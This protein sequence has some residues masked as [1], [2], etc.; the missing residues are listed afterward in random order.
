MSIEKNKR[1]NHFL[2]ESMIELLKHPQASMNG[3]RGQFK[4]SAGRRWSSTSRP[5]DSVRLTMRDCRGC[6]DNTISPCHQYCLPDR[7]SPCPVP[8]RF[9]SRFSQKEQTIEKLSSYLIVFYRTIIVLSIGHRS[10]ARS[11]RVEGIRTVLTDVTGQICTR[12]WTDWT[13]D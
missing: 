9:P 1:Q 12:C 13:A 7:F 11:S 6:F 8:H 5:M 4:A 2:F 10:C 3:S